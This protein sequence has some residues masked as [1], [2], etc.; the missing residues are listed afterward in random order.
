VG[1]SPRARATRGRR[2][3]RRS[4]RAPASRAPRSVRLTRARRGV[5]RAF[6]WAVVAGD[7][8]HGVAPRRRRV[9]MLA[10]PAPAGT[11]VAHPN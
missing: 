1:C 2:A 9:A 11:A 8:V 7:A 5:A 6:G 10:L 3:R 4:H